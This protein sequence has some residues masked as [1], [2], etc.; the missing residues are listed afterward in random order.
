MG[1]EV[2]EEAETPRSTQEEPQ[3]E[4]VE[5]RKVSALLHD[6]NIPDN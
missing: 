1:Q 3:P 6:T 4:V 2:L 5:E